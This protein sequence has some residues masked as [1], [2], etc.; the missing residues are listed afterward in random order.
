MLGRSRVVAQRRLVSLGPLAVEY[1]LKW[2][3]RRHAN[4]C[5]RGS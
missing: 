2:R 1:T 4:T 3:A 5:A